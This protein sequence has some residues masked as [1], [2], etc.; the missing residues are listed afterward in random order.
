MTIRPY[1]ATLD[2]RIFVILHDNAG[3]RETL[4]SDILSV[5]STA[6]CHQTAN[7]DAAITE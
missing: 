7:A 5:V 2:H 4:Q 6:A 3:G 1:T